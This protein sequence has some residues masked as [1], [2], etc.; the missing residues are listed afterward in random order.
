[1]NR[2]DQELLNWPIGRLQQ[3]SRRDGV[4]VLVLVAAFL[5]GMATASIFSF[6]SHSTAQPPSEDGKTALAFFLNGAQKATR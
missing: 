4:I 5:A 2:H 3:L 1:M 6:G